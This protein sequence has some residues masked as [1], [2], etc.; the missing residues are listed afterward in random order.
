VLDTKVLLHNVD[1]ISSFSDIIVVDEAQNLTPHDIKNIISRAGEA[2]KNSAYR[3]SIPDRQPLARL[4]Q[5]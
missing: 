5:Q 1:A 2:T 3:L 4:T